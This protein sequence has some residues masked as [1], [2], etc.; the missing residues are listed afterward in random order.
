YFRLE[1]Y[2]RGMMQSSLVKRDIVSW[3]PN[4]WIVGVMNNFSSKAYDWNELVQKKIIQDSVNGL[5]ILLTIE[6][7]TTSFHVYDRRVNDS[8][9]KFEISGINDLLVD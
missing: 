9:L 4:S 7:D 3:E 8:V 2:D 5:P 1:D 6:K